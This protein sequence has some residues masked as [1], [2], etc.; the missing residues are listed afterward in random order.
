MKNEKG[1]IILTI[2]VGIAI[3]IGSIMAKQAGTDVWCY[4]FLFA[5]GVLTI[6]SCI[7]SHGAK[8]LI[9]S[10]LLLMTLPSLGQ[11][12]QETIKINKRA[13][14]TTYTAWYEKH[15]DIW[16]I[17]CVEMTASPKQQYTGT[18]TYWTT[19]RECFP[20]LE[21]KEKVG[22]YDF[23]DKKVRMKY[24]IGYYITGELWKKELE[25]S[26]AKVKKSSE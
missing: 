24:L 11:S 7:T 12:F 15:G 14:T 26:I 20:R 19:D 13:E 23:S 25:A 21:R 6:A 4:G 10:M 16:T 22:N 8:S 17:S 2:V 18:M 3:I 5:I 1:A 9:I